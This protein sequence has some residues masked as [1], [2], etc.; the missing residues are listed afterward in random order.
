MVTGVLDWPLAPVPSPLVSAGPRVC[1][2]ALDQYRHGL[3]P[4]R[5]LDLRA[6]APTLRQQVEHLVTT[7]PD[8]GPLGLFDYEGIPGGIT[9]P[10]SITELQRRC[11][12]QGH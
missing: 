10:A 7:C 9:N 3:L 5:W 4:G 1:V 11:Q 12:E 2:V 6:S 8:G